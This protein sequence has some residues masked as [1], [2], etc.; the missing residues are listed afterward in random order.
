MPGVSEKKKH[1]I[2]WLHIWFIYKKCIPLQRK[3]ERDVAQ[4]G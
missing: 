2:F 1:E 4:P 3:T